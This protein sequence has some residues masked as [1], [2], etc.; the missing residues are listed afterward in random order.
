MP[1]IR[2]KDKGERESEKERERER[3]R[4]REREEKRVRERDAHSL[5]CGSKVGQNAKG[6]LLAHSMQHLASETNLGI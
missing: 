4:E 5:I 2:A 3:K 6:M 1:H